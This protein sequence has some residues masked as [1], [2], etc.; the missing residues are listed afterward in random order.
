MTIQEL[1]KMGMKRDLSEI[2]EPGPG[3]VLDLGAGNEGIDWATPLDLP[4]W[5][6]EL[7][8]IPR[9]DESVA[10]IY[11]FHFFE[12]FTGRRAIKLLRECERVLVPGG[13]LTIVV[14]HRLG[15]MAFHDLDHKSFWCEDTLKTL[16]GNPYYDKH[17]EWKM[18]VT[19]SMIAGVVERNLCLM[20]QLVKDGE[21]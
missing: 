20:A 15:S 21:Q 10:A 7:C 14:P 11:A 4:G 18:S 3:E 2:R 16:L 1:F 8:D 19:F 6:A 5:D 12:H 13:V 17:G 9:K